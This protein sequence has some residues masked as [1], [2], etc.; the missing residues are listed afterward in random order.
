M[1]KVIATADPPADEQNIPVLRTKKASISRLT[2]S[3]NFLHT[4]LRKEKGIRNY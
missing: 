4:A 1:D 3:P 2:C